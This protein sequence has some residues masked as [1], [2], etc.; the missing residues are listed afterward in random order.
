MIWFVIAK[1]VPWM[2]IVF[3][4][5][6]LF[7]LFFAIPWSKQQPTEVWALAKIRF[8]LKPRKRLWDQTS[9]NHL[10]T[11]TAPKNIPNP[12]A[13]NL[14]AR[15]VKSR[16]NALAD[17]I[18]SRGWAV[19]NVELGYYDQPEFL[20]NFQNSDRLVNAY[21][22][23][24][25]DANTDAANSP[26]MFDMQANPVAQKLD[27]MMA[28]SA[29]ERRQQ[30]VQQTNMRLN[31]QEPDTSQQDSYWHMK[32]IM[33]PNHAEQPAQPVQQAQPGLPGSLPSPVDPS[34]PA[35][36]PVGY[37]YQPTAPAPAQPEPAERP[38]LRPTFISGLGGD[39]N[40]EQPVT[41][42]PNPAILDLANNNDLNVA[43]IA[44]E[45][46]ARNGQSE[47]GEVVVSLH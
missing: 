47:D 18:D 17:T 4:P 37:T 20:K 5:F 46:Q 28:Q 24:Q 42:P 2:M 16:L 1:G 7:G 39:Q 27:Q 33:P 31:G 19:K 45:A 26:D 9:V 36:L 12:Y 3:I 14:S 38:M 22:L 23:P 11:I 25:A 15:E 13:H 30:L 43:T 34:N 21:N 10:V 41:P 8:F 6:F 32:T 44:R 29:G 35:P 40:T